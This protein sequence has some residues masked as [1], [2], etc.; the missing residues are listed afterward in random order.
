MGGYRS[1]STTRGGGVRRGNPKLFFCCRDVFFNGAL[2][3]G[4]ARERAKKKQRKDG[5]TDRGIAVDTGDVRHPK[6]KGEASS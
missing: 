1:S 4:D 2:L 6:G 5:M 3:R